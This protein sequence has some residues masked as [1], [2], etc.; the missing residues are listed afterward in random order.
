MLA[1]F[2]SKG[3]LTVRLLED[4]SIDISIVKQRI[5][6]YEYYF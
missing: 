2:S 3:F 4:S 5:G 6:K 1:T